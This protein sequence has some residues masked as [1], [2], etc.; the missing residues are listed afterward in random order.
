MKTVYEPLQ[1][2]D[3]KTGLFYRAWE[4]PE[5]LPLADV[6]ILT[7]PPEGMKEP[8]YSTLR[9]IWEDGS[10]AGMQEQTEQALADKEAA[11]KEAETATQ[12]AEEAKKQYLDTLTTLGELLSDESLPEEVKQA[13]LAIYPAWTVGLMYKTGDVVQYNG[14]IYRYIATEPMTATE[15]LNPADAAYMWV[16]NNVNADGVQVWKLPTG[17]QN[18]YAKGD[19]VIYEPDGKKYTSLVDGNTQEPT[20]DEPYNRY[21]KPAE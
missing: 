20:K 4:V 6:L 14:E 15:Q 18:A 12:Q 19:V 16:I 21:W 7:A 11:E 9:G 8:K 10:L 1:T 2:K 5:G 13:L 3:P 17:Y